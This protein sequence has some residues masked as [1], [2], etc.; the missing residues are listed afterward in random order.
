MTATEEP[1]GP[2]GIRPLGERAVLMDVGGAHRGAAAL[3]RRITAEEVIPTSGTVG[4]VGEY[5]LGPPSPRSLPPRRHEVE[6]SFDGEDVGVG[7]ISRSEL[8]ACCADL[9]LEVAFIGFMP[10]FAYL[11]GL[12]E[13]LAALP[14]R[15]VPRPSVPAGSFAVAGGY[16][17]I[18]PTSSP[19]GWNL[20]GTTA[21]RAFEPLSP[22]YAVLQPGDT[23]RLRP[24]ARVETQTPAPRQGLTGSA[25]EVLT[26]GPLLLVEDGG[27]R[28][29]ASLGVPR[30]GAANPLWRAVANTAVG[31]GLDEAVLETAGGSELRLR[32]DVL[33]A[34]AGEAA[35]LLDGSPLPP[36]TVAAVAAGQTLTVGAVRRFGRA[37]LAVSGGMRWHG[38]FD[39]LASDPVSGLPPGPLRPGD[40]LDLGPRPPRGRLR[41]ELP[42]P[43]SPALLRAVRGP[44][45]V[46][47]AVP[48][49][50]FVVSEKSDRTGTRLRPEGSGRTLEGGGLAASHA[51]IPGALQLP[52]GG[53]PVILGPDCGP[54]GGYPVAATVIGADLWKLGALVPGDEVEIA[55]VSIEEA[56]S[57]GA[58]PDVAAHVS[59]WYPVAF[60]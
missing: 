28:G 20:L 3:A 46:A 6:V 41:F 8:E 13:R 32:R 22:P 60:A 51:V 55:L 48:E 36:G 27:R 31:N 34:L 29:V 25:L 54:V 37:V 59:G 12:P 33:V 1:D 49:G 38:L 52:P 7:G 11:V 15:P 35:L 19:G 24:V 17:G 44:D 50:R 30:A 5:V 56:R 21:F 43:G 2:A 23:V 53:E 40:V 45:A 9:E 58:G 26:P 47:G 4:V 39:S 16:A 10:G 18:Y 42:R 14:R 57:E